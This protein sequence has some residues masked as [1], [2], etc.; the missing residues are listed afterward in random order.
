MLVDALDHLVR[1]IVDNPD[2]VSVRTRE[3]R[4]GRNPRFTRQPRRDPRGAGQP[5]RP[6]PGHRPVGSDRHRAA[7]RAPGAQRQEQHPGRLRRCR[8]P[9]LTTPPDPV[10]RRDGRPTTEPSD[11]RDRSSA[12]SAGPTGC[13]ATCSSTSAPTSPSGGSRR[14]PVFA[15]RRGELDLESTRWHGAGCS[16]GSRR[17]RTATAPSGCAAPSC[18]STYPPTSARTTPRSS[19]TT[20]CAAS[21]PTSRTVQR[22]GAGRR[23]AAPARRRTSSS[24]DVGRGRGAGAVR[25]RDRD[26][27]RPRRRPRRRRRPA[28]P[29][30]RAADADEGRGVTSMRVDVVTIFPDYLAPLE[31]CRCSVGRRPTGCCRS[32]HPRPARL[33]PRPAPHRR[34]HA[35][36]RRRGHGD[37]AGAVGR[38][39]RRG[40]R[41]RAERRAR[42]DARRPDA[43]RDAVRPAAG[44]AAG[45]QSRGWSFACGRYEGI[46][47]RVVDHFARAGRRPSRSASVTTC[48]TAARSAALVDHRGGGPAAAGLRRQP[49]LARRGV[50]RRRRRMRGLLEYPVYTKPPTWRGLD[51]PEVLLSGHHGRIEA[52][53]PRRSRYDGP[54]SAAPTCSPEPDAARSPA[55][56]ATPR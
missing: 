13:A 44:R 10:D 36:R 6:R 55:W 42:A 2:D 50:A 5:R 30:R 31:L 22:I 19:T 23:R 8:P 28:G 29:A 33:D 35:V 47:Q 15:T 18:G 54:P 21:R 26:L 9:A 4:G 11:R 17:R 43:D 32:A 51:V 20:S 3:A 46:D 12:R 41:G 52:L 56:S 1:G 34:R 14:G 24:L 48:S 40:P 38:G 16:S 7:H 39:D 27:G 53:A 25:G 37:A 45:R 49:R